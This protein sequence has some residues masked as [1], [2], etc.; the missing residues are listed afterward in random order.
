IAFR[1]E[2]RAF[3]AENYPAG[4]RERQEEGEEM[5]KEDFLSWHRVLAKKGWVNPAWPS[6]YGG[7]GWSATQ[8]YIWSEECAR[9]D[10]VPILPLG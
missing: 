9:A 2:V 1:D 7:P 8:R 6:Q 5:A 10:T 4:L 3:I